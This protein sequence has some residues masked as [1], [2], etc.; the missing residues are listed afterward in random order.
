MTPAY[1]TDQTFAFLS[2]LAQNNNRDWFLAHKAQYERD[3]RDPA[4]KL[5]SD[6]KAPMLKLSAEFVPDPRPNGGSLFRIHRDAR[7]SHD[8]TPYKTHLGIR[9]QHTQGKLRPAPV[10]Y[11][12]IEP[13]R[14]FI[15]GGLWHPEPKLLTQVR[16]FIVANP[17][18]WQ[19][20]RD[21]PPLK[22]TFTLGGESLTRPPRGYPPDHPLLEDLKRKDF[23]AIGSLTQAQILSTELPDLVIAHFKAI[24][25]L[26]DWLCAA[27]ELEY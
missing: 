14:C 23:V 2:A 17:N 24:G 10:F 6:L 18:S 4:L 5:L 16:D 26:I 25:P 8:K 19:T 27:L 21:H 15:G 22:K 3:A 20:A 11:L 12:H 7:F 1:F 13:E 9:I